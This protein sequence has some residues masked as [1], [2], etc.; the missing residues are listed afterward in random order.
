MKLDL[1][2]AV[3]F[4]FLF[5]IIYFSYLSLAKVYLGHPYNDY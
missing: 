4:L 5:H 3:A 1:R 2:F